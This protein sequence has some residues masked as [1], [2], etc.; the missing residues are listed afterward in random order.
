MWQKLALGLIWA[1]ASLLWSI[2]AA[3]NEPTAGTY[4][5][6]GG[7]YIISVK[8]DGKAL[9]LQEPNKTTSYSA[10]GDGSYHAF[11]PNTNATYG[12]RRIDERTIEAFKPGTN[13]APSRLILIASATPAGPAMVSDESEKW[14]EMAQRYL[15][16]S[17]SDPANA[18]KWTACGAVAMKRSVSS[19][20]D[21]DAYAAQIA[22]M[23]QQLYSTS[24]PC[25]DVLQF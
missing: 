4:Q 9:L 18:Q 3:A 22:A 16:R 11:N 15:E 12:I 25:P 2:S 7:S 6:E 20:A 10:Q 5:L 24:S 17:Q 23:L 21:A 8:M 19:K 13:N 14:E 1:W